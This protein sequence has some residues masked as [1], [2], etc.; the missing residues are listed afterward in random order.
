HIV[1]DGW[2]MGVL[3]REVSTLYAAFA[4][5]AP[6][7][8]PPLRMQYADY[9]LW[10]RSWLAGEVAQQQLAFWRGALAGAPPLLELPTDRPRAARPGSRGGH[11][12]FSLSTG[13][14]QALARSEGATLFM[15]LRAAWQALLG[16]WA[17][18]EDVV[19][20]TPV[21]N[22]TRV[23]V[24]HLIGFF[25]NTLAL[26]ADLGGDPTFRELLGRV[27]ETTRGAYAH[28]DVPFER[29]VEEL[30]VERS[31]SST[32]LFQAMLVLQ[33]N[34]QGA[35]SLGEVELGRLEHGGATSKF[36]LLLAAGEAGG[37][38]AGVV[39]YRTELFDG[40]TV[41]RMVGHL[42]ALLVAAALHP[43]RRL[44][45]LEL[46]SG[47]ER[48]QVVEGWNATAAAY[49][50]G[51]CVHE[52]FEAQAE[53]TPRAVAVAYDGGTL[54]Y[55]ELEAR[56]NRLARLLRGRGVGP[57]TRVGLCLERGP[58][59]MV[60]VLGILKAGG[61][62]VPLDPAYPAERLAYMLESCAAPVLL[63]QDSLAGRLPASG[64]AVVRLDG[65]AEA[66]QG[67][68]AERLPAGAH[69]ESLAYV[70]YTSG[71]TGRPKGVA[72]PHRPLVNLL[73]WQEGAWAGRAAAVTLQ[74]ATISFDVSFQEIFSAWSTGGRVVLIGEET[75]YDPAAI[76]EVLERE[77]VERLFMPAVA[78]QA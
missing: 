67:E 23:E 12:R 63:T 38:L 1:S 17:G 59:M 26:R 9:A 71:S 42:R 51:R 62:Y 32:P 14:L 77:G 46:L 33:N 39:E 55:A 74:F 47:D 31:L 8:L 76:L 61:A 34:E 68:S 13:A 24:E 43:E 41:E 18:Q 64:A 25:A 15:T 40:A 30:G 75:R 21:A 7:P 72:M 11:H 52:L 36:D 56:S 2:S 60:A 5:G 29:L 49:P 6:S 3:V 37:A 78:L 69:P 73:A 44:S 66:V 4:R 48:R 28:Q 20:G 27:R 19:V 65:D 58:Q 53:R 35:L 16:R 45:E 54:T 57:D 70:V 50:A 10:H 22:R